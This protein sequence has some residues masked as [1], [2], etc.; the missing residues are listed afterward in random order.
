[1]R[2]GL[3]D[4]TTSIETPEHVQFEYRV[5]G[6]ARRMFAHLLDVA[7]VY[8]VLIFL[9]IVL[10]V[11]ASSLSD[12]SAQIEGASSA[13]VGIFLVL[14]FLAQ[15]VYFAV[16]EAWKGRSL[17][18]M[19]LSLRVVT[20]TGRP[21]GVRAAALRNLLRAADFLPFGYAVGVLSQMATTRF[22]RLGDLVAE[23]MVIIEE[24]R[25]VG[26]PIVLHPQASAEELSGLPFSIRLS[27]DEKAALELFL[28]RRAQFGAD[29]ERELANMVAPMFAE[30]FRVQYKDPTR[31]LAVIYDLA[32]NTGREDAPVSSRGGSLWP[33][34]AS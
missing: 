24:P 2:E 8:G 20:T 18:K 9:G 13:T 30:R 32:T 22:Q 1:M 11:A 31:F 6:P 34:S 19:A 27:P 26:R 25:T 28:R 7:L 14:L 15:W 16:C 3:L 33:S 4:T 5:A 29:R 21:I 23:T 17:G 10:V 12:I